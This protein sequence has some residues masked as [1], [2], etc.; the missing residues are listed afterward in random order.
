MIAW[1]VAVP[2]IA[3]HVIG[4]QV[5]LVNPRQI[6]SLIGQQT[7]HLMTAQAACVV[8][9]ANGKFLSVIETCAQVRTLMEKQGNGERV[10]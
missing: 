9:F 1:A 5:V 8:T 4:G 10:R 2:L 3:L 6:V 7:G